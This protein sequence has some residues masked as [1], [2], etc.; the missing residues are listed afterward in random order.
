MKQGGRGGSTVFAGHLKKNGETAANIH[1]ASTLMT[2][3]TRK[4]DDFRRR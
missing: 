3:S 2:H 1:R 4:R